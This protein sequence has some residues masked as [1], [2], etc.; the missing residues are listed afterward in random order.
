MI[1]KTHPAQWNKIVSMIVTVIVIMTKI[2]ATVTV[3]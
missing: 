3:Q 2:T 1:T